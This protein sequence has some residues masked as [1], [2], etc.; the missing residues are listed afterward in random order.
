MKIFI[1]NIKELEEIMKFYESVPSEMDLFDMF[2]DKLKL[3]YEVVNDI[4]ESDIAFIPIDFIKLIYGRITH[5]N[6]NNL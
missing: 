1:Y 2:L 4:N 3:K 6:H 5:I